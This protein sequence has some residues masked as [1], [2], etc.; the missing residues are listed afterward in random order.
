MWRLQNKKGAKTVDLVISISKMSFIFV[1][2]YELQVKFKIILS[3]RNIWQWKAD[4]ITFPNS[5][6]KIYFLAP[7][8]AD[9]RSWSSRQNRSA[10]PAKKTTGNIA[11]CSLLPKWDLHISFLM[12]LNRKFLQWGF[13][14]LNVVWI[15]KIRYLSITNFHTSCASV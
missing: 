13:C 10:C 6:G 4:N 15:S 5:T 3:I 7:D 11:F 9:T 1:L 8:F 12:Y 2:H 14:G